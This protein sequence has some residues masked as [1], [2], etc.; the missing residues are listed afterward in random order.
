MEEG[1][2]DVVAMEALLQPEEQGDIVLVMVSLTV[3][4]VG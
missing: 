4:P 3:V 2:V 1:Q